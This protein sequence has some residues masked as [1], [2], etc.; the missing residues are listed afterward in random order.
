LNELARQAPMPSGV[1]SYNPPERFAAPGPGDGPLGKTHDV[2]DAFLR[3]PD[4]DTQLKYAYQGDSLRP[5][6]EEYH[7]KWPFQQTD[8]F[9]LQ[10]FSMELDPS[11]G[12]PYWVY[13]VSTSD[14][15]QGYPVI[16]R[17]EGGDLKVD[18]EVYSEFRDKHY[19]KFLEGSIASP[20]TLR[21]VIERV[22][23]Y[24]GPDREAFPNLSD[25]YVYQ[26]NPP[27]GGLNEFSSYAFVKKDSQLASE[28]DSVVGLNEEPLA[29]IVTLEEKP[30]AHG[31]NHLMVTDY[32]TEGWFR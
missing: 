11:V 18:W 27:Y 7:E 8:R 25:Y 28:L 24:Y 19:V 15:D 2:I 1:S 32:V 16:V 4:W 5:A 10:L 21:V 6:V 17:T 20:H 26:V 31:I 3:A 23:D 12:G 29:V 13:L 9:S 30:F 22:S 14:I